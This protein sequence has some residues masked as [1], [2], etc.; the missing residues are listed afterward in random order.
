LATGQTEDQWVAAYFRPYVGGL[1]CPSDLP[2]APRLPIDGHSGYLNVAGCEASS[3]GAIASRDV[4]FTAFV[5][6]GNRVY[7]I[8]LDGDVDL[9]YFEAVLATLTLDPSSAIDPP[10]PS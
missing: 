1:P 6:A 3:D 7:Q 5:F 8:T 10:N 9:A 4:E 2:T